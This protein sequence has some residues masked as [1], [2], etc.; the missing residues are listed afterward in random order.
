MHGANGPA[1]IRHVFSID[2]TDNCSSSSSNNGGGF[3]GPGAVVENNNDHDP[4]ADSQPIG[5]STFLKT[6]TN[7]CLDTGQRYDTWAGGRE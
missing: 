7:A 4:I 2:D 1:Q 3:H 5:A 6:S